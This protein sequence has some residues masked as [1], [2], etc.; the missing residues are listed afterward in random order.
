[1]TISSKPDAQIQADVIQELAWDTRIGATDVGVEVDGGVVTLTGTVSSWAKRVAA[2]E[3]AHRV[4]GVLDVANDLQVRLS[5]AA[6]RTDT[7]IAQAVR[8]ALEWNVMVPDRQIRTTVSN[9]TVTLGG[10]VEYASQREDAER[11]VRNLDGIRLVVNEIVVRPAHAVE[12]SEIHR[13]IE[14]ALVRQAARH[15]AAIELRVQ[16]GHV[17]VDGVVRSGAERDAVIGAVRGT[18]GVT[19]VASHLRVDA[20]GAGTG[21]VCP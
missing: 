2:Q 1:M 11:C 18:R 4:V 19:A 20:D 16:D 3:A 10:D 17:V 13:S 8:T 5:G 12:A 7:E 9:G 21:R 14:D 15:A 6:G